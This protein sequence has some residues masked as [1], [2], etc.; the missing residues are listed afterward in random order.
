MAECLPCQQNQ[1]YIPPGVNYT[2]NGTQTLNHSGCDGITLG[3]L[4]MWQGLIVCVRRNNLYSQTQTSNAEIKAFEDILSSWIT[5]KQADA[6][7]CAYQE[8]LPLLQTII[9]R[10]V[11]FGQC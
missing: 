6:A 1:T 5:T 11:L 8:H 10:I 4:S 7:S 3:L 2:Y 9:N